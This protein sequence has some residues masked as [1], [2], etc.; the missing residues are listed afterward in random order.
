MKEVDPK[1]E[2]HFLEIM[3]TPL[4][5]KEG[6]IREGRDNGSGSRYNREKGSKSW[7]ALCH[8]CWIPGETFIYQTATRIDLHSMRRKGRSTP[9]SKLSVKDRE[10]Q[11]EVVCTDREPGTGYR[12]R[13]WQK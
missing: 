11:G 2:H 9:G 3:P 8:S 1:E 4:A 10:D 7:G 6:T 12:R 5:P 13:E